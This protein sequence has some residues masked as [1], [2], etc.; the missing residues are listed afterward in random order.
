LVKPGGLFI[1][2]DIETSYWKDGKVYGH[3]VNVDVSG[4]SQASNAAS[5]KFR[6]L[7]VI[8]IFKKAIDRVLNREF[9]QV[10]SG[11]VLGEQEL[12]IESIQFATNCIIIRKQAAGTCQ[13]WDRKYRFGDSHSPRYRD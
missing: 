7:S 6:S 1:I 12:H 2:E 9:H 3:E 5:T 8:N 10:P 13:Y 4:S 11:S